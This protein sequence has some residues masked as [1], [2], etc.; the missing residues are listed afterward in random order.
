MIRMAFALLLTL[1]GLLAASLW[2]QAGLSPESLG[3]HAGL[4]GESVDWQGV[5]PAEPNTPSPAVRAEL[6]NGLA[7]LREAAS[8]WLS[9]AASAASPD[10]SAPSP[11][12]PVLSPEPRVPEEGSEGIATSPQ[13]DRRRALER[14]EAHAPSV[15]RV[16]ARAPA[17]ER[18]EARTSAAEGGLAASEWNDTPAPDASGGSGN[19][20]V[21]EPT[22]AVADDA[23]PLGTF[24]ETDLEESDDIVRR[25]LAIYAR[26]EAT[27]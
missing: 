19:V 10:V 18:V 24:R 14:V 27:L 17:V 5:D 26:L 4:A 12:I 20:D 3:P 1:A 6:A 16:D 23:I 25:L 11:R 9:S 22:P 21:A 15:E 7:E 13:P 2:W 8:S